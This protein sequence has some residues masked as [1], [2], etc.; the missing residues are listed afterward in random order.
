[1]EKE[2]F[3]VYFKDEPELYS[4]VHLDL[5][6]VV[7]IWCRGFV[8]VKPLY[9]RRPVGAVTVRLSLYPFPARRR[10]NHGLPKDL[11]RPSQK[12]PKLPKITFK[13]ALK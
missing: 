10:V 13:R 9:Q 7:V 3:Y 1:M 6:L 5:G 11:Q 4:N 12:T 8:R 2:K